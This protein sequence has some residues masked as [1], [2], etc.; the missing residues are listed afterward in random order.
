[1]DIADPVV[2]SG[3]LHFANADEATAGKD[4]LKAL[5][6]LARDELKKF[7][8]ELLDKVIGDG[9]VAPIDELP[10]AALSLLGLGAIERLDE[11]LAKP[12]LTRSGKSLAVEIK[13]PGGSGFV[14][15][16]AVGAGLLL[17]AVQKVRDA[18][19]RVTSQNNLKQ[20]GLALHNYESAYGSFPPAAICDKK[21]KPLLSWRVAILPFIEQN[22]LYQQFKLDEPWDSEHNIKLSRTLVKVYM[23]PQAPASTEVG[24]THYRVFHSNGAL[25]DL[26]KNRRIADITDGTSNT[27]MVFE[28]AE[29]VPW[30]KPDDFEYDPKKPLPKFASFSRGGFN[31]L[32]ADGSVRFISDT[33]PEKTL[34]A[35]ITA[36][37]GEVID[38]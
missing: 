30:A 20:I 5:A 6:N 31:V 21:G 8:Q 3:G 24:L 18:A 22:N 1:L 14:G 33:T 36:H 15:M 9:K 29:G 12:P 23:H 34:R 26:I 11:F 28:S 7:R 25:F 38:E 16:A 17:P 13:L 10:M 37:G 4:A 35:M 32:F 19:G 2:I 27:W